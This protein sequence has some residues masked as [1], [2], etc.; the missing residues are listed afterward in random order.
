M[1]ETKDTKSLSFFGHLE[2]LRWRLVRVAVV[3]LV[4]ALVLFV[5]RKEAMDTVFLSM[6]HPDFP[7]YLWFC[8]IGQLTGID[9]LCVSAPLELTVQSD[10][11]MGEFS[12]SMFYSIIGGI[13]LSF[14][15]LFYQIWTFVKP[16]LKQNEL[17]ASK[18][19]IFYTSFLF[20]LGIA[21]GYFILSPL[22]VQFAGTFNLS[23]QI[24]NLPS[25]SSFMSMIV[26]TTFYTGLLFELPVI[27]FL[28]TKIGVIGPA[29]L[30]KFRKHAIVVI[31]IV[32]AIITPPDIISQ[33]IVSIP[34]MILYEIS[35]LISVRTERKRL[36]KQKTA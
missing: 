23:D 22:C 30:R 13:I 33:M 28:L 24:V 14:P 18:G 5:Y 20:F 1:S 11:M 15:V 7:T 9:D 27:V 12:A 6:L 35:I 31:L 26:M 36:Q 21:F 32:A 3:I 17:S 19:I 10:T 4:F 16:A 29:F 2:E 34:I 25:I 8:E